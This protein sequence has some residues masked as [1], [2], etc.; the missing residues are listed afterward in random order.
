MSCCYRKRMKGNSKCFWQDCKG[1][2]KKTLLLPFFLIC[3][4][5]SKRH[6]WVLKL[7]GRPVVFEPNFCKIS[8][9][10]LMIEYL[11][12]RWSFNGL[13]SLFFFLSFFLRLDIF[14][15]VFESLESGVEEIWLK[16]FFLL[17]AFFKVCRLMT[18]LWINEW[19]NEWMLASIAGDK[20]F[21][22]Y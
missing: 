2:R 1:Y 7:Y 11:T 8:V 5:A 9:H 19:I 10:L 17:E 16:S 6:Y 15:T 3:S 18:D 13:F 14:R 12:Q 20:I 21:R 4:P 22:K